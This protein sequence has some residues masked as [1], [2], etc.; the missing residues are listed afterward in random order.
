VRLEQETVYTILLTQITFMVLPFM[1]EGDARVETEE[2]W[3]KRLGPVGPR[4]ESP[5]EEG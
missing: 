1:F 4:M 2:W 3:E 5:E